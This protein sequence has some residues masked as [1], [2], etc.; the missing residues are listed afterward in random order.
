MSNPNF[1]LLFVGATF[2][3]KARSREANAKTSFSCI[4]SKGIESIM[5]DF[6]SLTV[7][8][9]GL[10]EHLQRLDR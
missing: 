8:P 7:T 9:I 1:D 2:G 5:A 10:C 6:S 3:G 4:Y